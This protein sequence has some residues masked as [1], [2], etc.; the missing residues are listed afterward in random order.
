VQNVVKLFEKIYLEKN[1]ERIILPKGLSWA[2]RWEGGAA[3]A[4]VL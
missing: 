1:L 4:A 2:E 3:P